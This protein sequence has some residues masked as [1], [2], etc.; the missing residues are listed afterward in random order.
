MGLMGG[1]LAHMGG[2]FAVAQVF[3]ALL[4]QHMLEEP[5]VLTG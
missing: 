3:G 5:Q 4:S 2:R 1:G